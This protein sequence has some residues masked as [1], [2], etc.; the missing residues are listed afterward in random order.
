MFIQD[1]DF[2]IPDPGSKRHRIPNPNQQQRIQIFLTQIIVT[3]LSEILS[4][5]L[6]SDSGP[7]STTDPGS[8]SATLRKRNFFHLL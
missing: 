6:N 5:I 3:K 7:F 2:S 8:E 4:G 1:P